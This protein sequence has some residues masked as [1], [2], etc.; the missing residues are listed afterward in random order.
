MVAVALFGRIQARVGPFD[1]TMTAT[2]MAG[3]GTEVQ[4]APLGRIDVDTH[5]GP[6]RLTLR[7]DELREQDALAIAEDPTTFPFDEAS[8]A[9]DVRHGI[10]RLVPRVGLA[11][12]LGGAT[13]AALWRR[14]WRS[15]VAGASVG[16]LLFALTA[17]AVARTWEPES[18]AEPRYSGLLRLA[19]QAIGDA[20]EVADR[21]T[22][23]RAQLAAIVENVAV[24]YQ[25]AERI[26]TFRPDAS[27][28]TVLHVSDLHLNPQGFDLMEQVVPQFAVDA[29]VDTGDLN[30]WGTTVEGRFAR[31][32][33]D[34]EVPYVFVRGNHD[35][36]ATARAVARQPNA[37]VLRGQTERVAGLTFWGRG[38]PRFT[39]DKSLAG[40]GDD[41]RQV[42]EET[43][44]V[45]AREVAD[46]AADIDVVAIHDPAI[47]A[48]LGDLVPLVLSGHL[49]HSDR[50]TLGEDTTLLVEGSTGGAGL[51]GLQG[52]ERVPLTCSVLYFDAGTGRLEALDRIVVSGIDSSEVRIERE[53]V[54]PGVAEADENGAR[55]GDGT[56]VS[57]PTTAPGRATAPP[58][59]RA[60]G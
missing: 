52:E 55:S 18:L 28:I 39:P 20:R 32:I 38:D 34:L 1:T 41:Q 60:G 3:G 50:R 45:V 11:A 51:R 17:G 56:G 22:D 10:G 5:E 59:G 24:L 2:P 54:D 25:S 53:V 9:A 16:L 23:H 33:R 35:S 13:G 48:D 14:S 37:V 36:A 4:L 40:S 43:A 21:F 15:A 30:D 44:P 6:V 46:E 49:H 12:I 19:P 47:T 26:Q 7:L 58:A 29:V 31:R 57:E 8:L 27:T 42:A